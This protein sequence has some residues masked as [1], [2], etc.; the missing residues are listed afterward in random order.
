MEAKLL[1][2]SIGGLFGLAFSTYVERAPFFLLLALAAFAASAIV[3]FM[4]PAVSLATQQGQFKL[5]ILILTGVVVD[6]YIIAAVAL[7]VG[8]RVGGA[9]ASSETLADAAVARWPRVVAVTV[10]ANI[11]ILS[12]SPYGGFIGL[13]EPRAVSL[14]AVPVTWL[15]WTMLGL[16]GPLAALS[17][18]RGP[19][20]IVTGFGRAFTVSLKRANLGRL[21]LLAAVTLIPMMLQA[22]LQNELELHHVARALFWAN[23]PIDALV[24]GP[25]AA[26]QTAFAL[27]FAR[28]SGVLETP[29]P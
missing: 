10:L 12:T 16:T 8:M 25:L 2:P 9:Q 4:L 24:V 19:L 28:R 6:A 1:P 20:A 11:Y 22:I 23:A 18:E 15:L 13:P 14:V 7:A 5:Y 17:A 29:K 3:E 27:D 21:C 26:L